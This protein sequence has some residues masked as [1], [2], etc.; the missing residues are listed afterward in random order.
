MPAKKPDVW[1]PESVRVILFYVVLAVVLAVFS[2]AFALRQK[3]RQGLRSDL[4][5]R[6]T[7]LQGAPV[8]SESEYETSRQTG[9]RMGILGVIGFSFWVIVPLVGQFLMAFMSVSNAGVWNPLGLSPPGSESWLQGFLIVAFISAAALVV[10][11]QWSSWVKLLFLEPCSL[12]DATIVMVTVGKKSHACTVEL[13]EDGQRFF[14]LMC[15]RYTFVPAEGRFRPVG[16]QLLSGRDVAEAMKKQGLESSIA[17]ERLARNGSNE[18]KVPVPSVLKSIFDEFHTVIYVYQLYAIWLNISAGFW[19]VPLLWFLL[20]TSAGLYRSLGITRRS[21]VKIRDMAEVKGSVTVLRDGGTPMLIDVAHVVPGDLLQV[22]RETTIPCDCVLAAGS[23]MMHEAMLTGE[24]MPIT[25]APLEPQEASAGKAS[26]L[27]GGTT[28]MEVT[29]GAAEAEGKALAVVQA[30]GGT[31]ERANLLRLVLFPSDYEF[32]YTKSLPKAYGILCA[33]ALFELLLLLV[34]PRPF[35]SKPSTYTIMQ[36]LY[37]VLQLISPLLG[38]AVAAGQAT[39]AGNLTN[40]GMMCLAPEKVPVAGNV[41]VLVLD[42]TGTIT[43]DGM[44]F[45]A[46]QLCTSGA[47]EATYAK[48]AESFAAGSR[49][50]GEL[51]DVPRYFLA[52]CHKL[53]LHKGDYIG[54]HVE[55]EMFMALGGWSLEVASGHRLLTDGRSSLEVLQVLDFDHTRMTSGCVCKLPDGSVHVFLKGAAA[56]IQKCCSTDAAFFQSTADK[57]SSESYYV[58]GCATK[59]LTDSSSAPRRTR[60]D[61]EQGLQPLGLLLFK[62]EVRPDSAEALEVLRQGSTPCVMC[63]G[64]HL[65][66]GVNVAKQVGI[67]PAGHRVLCLELEGSQLVWRVLEGEDHE[68]GGTGKSSL[69][70]LAAASGS[71]VMEQAAWDVLRESS[72]LRS[73]LARVRVF[74]RMRPEGKVAVIEELQAMGHCVGMCGDGGNDCGALR[75]AHIGVALSSSDASIVAPFS[76]ASDLSLFRVSDVLRE[77]R[78]CLS[79]N[80]ACFL[81]FVAYGLGATTQKLMLLVYSGTSASEW[82]WLY[83]DIFLS[84]C[85]PAQMIRCQASERLSPYRPTS[86]LLGTRVMVSIL[87][88]WAIQVVFLVILWIALFTQPFYVK[89]DPEVIGLTAADFQKQAD[90]FEGEVTWMA[91]ALHLATCCLA[92]S[93]GSHHRKALY[94]NVRLLVAYAVLVGGLA[95][96]LFT[97]RGKFNCMVRVNCDSEASVNAY[98]PVISDITLAGLGG[99]MMA[100]QMQFWSSNA[101]RVSSVVEE[102]LGHKAP[103]CVPS[104]ATMEAENIPPEF[105]DPAAINNVLPPY[106][107]WVVAAVL[108]TYATTMNVFQQLVVLNR[109]FDIAERQQEQCALAGDASSGAASEAPAGLLDPRG[110][111]VELGETFS[112]S[113]QGRSLV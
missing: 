51:P 57:W 29:G 94:T 98:I 37:C 27:Y 63:T 107:R 99:C 47:M 3:R 93:H 71:V 86:W 76:A 54:N 103:R 13:A 92:Y 95:T 68:P 77:G 5:R 16:L 55:R 102:A 104:T 101:S 30:V 41:D 18:V 81:Y 110:A 88:S 7:L 84:I 11:A 113:Q 80:V 74:G 90:N 36:A 28:V 6:V 75:A 87:S 105:R 43:K 21:R 10:S 64:D 45:Q 61:L 82:Q 39:S 96:A 89:A 34:I 23:V 22:E 70:A 85:L 15:Y 24:P 97:E 40:K 53:T 108:L 2:T 79:T 32:G 12:E 65:L 72:H 48:G 38:V 69:R 58:L 26:F 14:Q 8:Q 66:T 91:L 60:V 1:T 78:A 56:A 83:N 109:R 49:A 31:T 46:M 4:E 106:F 62:N 42:K 67:I 50:L 73:V 9:Y 25:K 20:V 33:Y 100:P 19:K 17:A 59:L 35:V 111:R 52:S 112:G 44:D